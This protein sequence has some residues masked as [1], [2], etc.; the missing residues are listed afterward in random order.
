M[1][2]GKQHLVFAIFKLVWSLYFFYSSCKHKQLEYIQH[3]ITILIKIK[4]Y[5][6]KH[7]DTMYI[8]CSTKVDW[9]NYFT[10]FLPLNDTHLYVD[11][12]NTG[13]V[14]LTLSSNPTITPKK[15]SS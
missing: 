14:K 3:N 7:E 1:N 2:T 5:T 10:L 12:K 11:R 8:Y 6:L 13:T 15:R 4:N 9:S